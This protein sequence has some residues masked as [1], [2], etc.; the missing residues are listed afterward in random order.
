MR[1]IQ[2]RL[3]ALESQSGAGGPERITRIILAPAGDN[4]P[5]TGYYAGDTVTHRLDGESED[6]CLERHLSATPDYLIAEL[7][8]GDQP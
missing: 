7:R 4:R 1:E 8:G 3:A 2:K 5:L 6:E